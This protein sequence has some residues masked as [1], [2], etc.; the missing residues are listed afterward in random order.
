VT[1]VASCPYASDHD[2]AGTVGQKVLQTTVTRT[3][4][5][6]SC[7]FY[8][9]DGLPTLHIAVTVLPT[10]TAA[11]DQA[12]ATGGGSAD[13]VTG[14]ADGGVVKVTN[15][16]TT[17][18]VSKGRALVVVEINQ[19]SSLEAEEIARLVVVRL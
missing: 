2:A 1:V 8:G 6:P 18:A 4:P 5:Y 16:G 19:M 11:Q 12:V 17:L 3:V 14:I 13:P 15:S 9:L 10:A 7:T